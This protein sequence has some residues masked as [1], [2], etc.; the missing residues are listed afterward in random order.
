VTETTEQSIAVPEALAFFIGYR[1]RKAV[2]FCATNRRQLPKFF[3]TNPTQAKIAQF[4][5]FISIDYSNPKI[6][7]G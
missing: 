4:Y 7:S 3:Y 5:L 1:V 6:W 2:N